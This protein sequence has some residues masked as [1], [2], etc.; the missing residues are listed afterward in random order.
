[1]KNLFYTLCIVLIANLSAST[2]DEQKEKLRVS[3]DN[4]N[5]ASCH[6]FRLFYGEETTLDKSSFAGACEAGNPIACYNMGVMNDHGDDDII[7]NDNTAIEFYTKACDKNY[8]KAC[9]RAAF[10]HE[11][12]KDVKVDMKKAFNLYAK[13]CGGNDG[14]A[15]HNVAVYY[16]KSDNTSLKKLAINF[17]DKACENGNA[18]SCIYM[19]RFYRDSRSLT[20]DYAKAKEKFNLACKLDSDLGCKEVRILKGLGY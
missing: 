11:Q 3:C 14:L 18:D 16:S 5:R 20:R 2:T 8:Y 10:L 4:G 12:G 17:Y 6:E 13:A 15:C 19:G 9:T 7:E 1:M